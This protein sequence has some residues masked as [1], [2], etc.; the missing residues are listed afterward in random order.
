MEFTETQKNRLTELGV[1]REA[2]ASNFNT[3][4]ERD[5][6]F[7][8]IEKTAAEK[9]KE[10]LRQL[11]GVSHKPALCRLQQEL[12]D[13]LCRNGFT[14]VTT[15]TIITSKAMEKMTIDQNNPL[16]KQVFWLDAKTCLRPMLA[17]NLYEVSRKIMTSQKLPLRI[18]EIGSCFRKESEGNSH[19]K[20]FTM[21]NLVEWGTPEDE[22]IDRL[23]GL[24]EL[25]LKTAQIDDYSL[26]EEDSVV[27]GIG[28]DV[29]SKDGLEL[30]ST[31]MGPHPLDDQWNMTCSWV[32]IGFGLERLLM[33]REKQ[34]GIQRY[35]KSN[36]FLDGVCL[37]IK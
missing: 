29:V 21:L 7:K 10:D 8:I 36:V 25:V 27:Y 34:N 11:L 2:A 13:A 17:P 20:E 33:H 18:F 12:A 26:Q 3:A 35:A 37:K 5:Q 6:A 16:Y 31:S 4:M 30:A 24:A 15:P 32:G 19:L 1:K 28:L 14:Q 23:K 22:R 9:N